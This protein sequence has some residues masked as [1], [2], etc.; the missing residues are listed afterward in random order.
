MKRRR[1]VIHEHHASRLHFDLRIGLDFREGEAKDV[2]LKPGASF[3][4][5]PYA[6]KVKNVEKAKDSL[7][8]KIQEVH[9]VTFAFD[10]P[11]QLTSMDFLKAL[12]FLGADGKEVKHSRKNFTGSFQG[13]G[14]HRLSIVILPVDGPLTVQWAVYGRIQT[15]LVPLKHEGPIRK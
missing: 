15:V 9:R 12:K 11:V 8:F 10:V 7:D 6:F 3:E 5:G 4:A 2:A 1:F 14:E 13:G